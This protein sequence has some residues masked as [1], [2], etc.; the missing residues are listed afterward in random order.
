PRLAH[1]AA[2]PHQPRARRLVAPQLRVGRA[3]VVDDPRHGRKGLDVV[4]Q[5]RPPPRALHGGQWGTGAGLGT[6]A[7][8]RLEKRRLLAADVGAVAAVEPD[9]ERVVLA[10]RLGA[11]VALGAS[12]LD[13]LGD[14][15]AGLVVLAAELD[16][17][18]G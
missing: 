5:R 8:E 2:P 15:P 3:A 9:V 4:E 11:G 12:L 10:H 7:F 6:L 14:G 18:R 1:A 16:R 17:G 13:S